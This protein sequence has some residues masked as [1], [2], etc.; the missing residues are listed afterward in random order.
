MADRLEIP[1]A[2]VAT[3]MTRAD[4]RVMVHSPPLHGQRIG[5]EGDSPS[6]PRGFSGSGEFPPSSLPGLC[7]PDGASFGLAERCAPWVGRCAERPT[8]QD[9]QI[10]IEL[11]SPSRRCAGAC[12][13]S[14]S[15]EAPA[16]ADCGGQALAALIDH[17]G[18]GHASVPKKSR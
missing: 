9:G 15:A 18:L 2:R 17:G 5:P 4:F 12:P 14:N 3:G 13:R 16:S 6:T 8:G 7:G 10:E 11:A 1:I